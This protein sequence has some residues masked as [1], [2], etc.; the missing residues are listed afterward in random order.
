MGISTFTLVGTLLACA[1]IGFQETG[2]PFGLVFPT[3]TAIGL[4][5]TTVPSELLVFIWLAMVSGAIVGDCVAVTLGRKAPDRVANVLRL[6]SPRLAAGVARHGAAILLLTR[7]V[8]VV[9]TIAP[10]TLGCLGTSNVRQ[11]IPFSAAGASLWS[12]ALLG[13]GKVATEFLLAAG[14]SRAQVVMC[15][16]VVAATGLVALAVAQARQRFDSRPSDRG[17][18]PPLQVSTK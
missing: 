10:T 13:G 6:R 8:P 18:G 15:V 4:V 2:T 17:P 7:F 12:A 1:I 16:L 11:V 3:T 5:S 14:L 9:R